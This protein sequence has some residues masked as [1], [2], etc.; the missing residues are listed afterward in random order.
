MALPKAVLCILGDEPAEHPAEAE[1]RSVGFATFSIT[2]KELDSQQ[3]G[4]IQLLPP[5]DD[6]AVV[7]WV[8]VG[9][10]KDFTKE[11][12]SK[13]AMLTLAMDRK[14]PPA[15]A[16]VLTD[17]GDFTDVPYALG[18]VQ[19]VQNNKKFAAKLMVAK[20]RPSPFPPL[21]FHVKMHLDPLVGAWLEMAPPENKKWD[22]FMIGTTNAKIAAFGVGPKGSLPS[23]STLKYPQLGIQGT[24]GEESF[25]ACAAQNELNDERSCYI[26][27]DGTPELVF[28]AD[29]PADNE[30]P[31]KT[32]ER[33]PVQLELV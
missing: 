8:L 14:T 32:T 21:P 15:T 16:L 7:A 26:R 2:W 28:C 1:L 29:Y 23:K 30:T 10:P 6:P 22:G 4:W 12:R 25:H 13:I 20:L 33:M 31:E 19:V 3:N 27:L 18:H 17:E 11:I 24:I 9:K 5:L